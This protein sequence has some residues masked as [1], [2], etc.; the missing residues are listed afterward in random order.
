M[1][2]ILNI[3]YFPQIWK[4]SYIIPLHTSGNKNEV[5]IYRNIDKLSS[6]PKLFKLIL[7]NQLSY[8][9][10][11]IISPH[12]H[13]FLKH[14][15]VETNL[16]EFVVKIFYGSSVGLQT[17]VTYTNFSK[18]IY[19]V[20]HSLHLTKLQLIALNPILLK[21]ISSY[22]SDRSQEAIFKNNFSDTLKVTSR[23]PQASHLGPILF[24]I[25]LNDLPTGLS[26]YI[27]VCR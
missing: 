13:G 16:F 5:S 20:N 27:N 6:I 21:R 18:A 17:V 25:F 11:Q 1:N 9:L 22:L 14:R 23:V 15:S 19:G 10:P 7:T 4:E 24:N 3:G 26:H 12:Q 8:L 2:K